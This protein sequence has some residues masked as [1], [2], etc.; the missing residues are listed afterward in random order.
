MPAP[1]TT[2]DDT[3][4]RQ[5]MSRGDHWD[6]QRHARDAGFVPT[7]AAPLLNV[8]AARPG[9]RILDLGCGDG[10]ATEPLLA[11]GCE[12]VAVD[13]SPAQVR[14]AR[15]RGHD[16]RLVD[17]QALAA[18]RAQLGQ[19]DAVFSNAALHW[20]RD[21]AAVF[22]GIASV[23]RPG[24]RLVVE[25]GGDG[26]VATI[27]DAL[28]AALRRRGIDPRTRDPWVFPTEA[29]TRERL[30]AAAFDVRTMSRFTQPTPL[31]GSLGDWL[32]TFAPT[33][34]VPFDDAARAEAI[35]EVEAACAPQLY[36]DGRWT[37]DHVRLRFTAERRPA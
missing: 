31:P 20:M 37:A 28:H 5:T 7:S 13:A 14:A 4:D 36:R 21:H 22:T 34:L 17:G 33:F 19:F 3:G 23:L 35:A 27:R 25:M 11:R 30:A 8:L 24:G 10:V 9:E 2:S 16:A 1:A 6:P 32:Q 15:S 26:N 18:A 12:L 29:A